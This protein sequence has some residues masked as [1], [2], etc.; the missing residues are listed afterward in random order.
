MKRLIWVGA[1]VGGTIGGYV[2]LLW[3]GSAFSFSSILFSAIGSIIG[4]WVMFR[5]QQ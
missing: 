5:I 1:A 4:I 3:G 2:P